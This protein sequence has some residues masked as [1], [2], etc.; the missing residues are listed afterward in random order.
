MQEV[1]HRRNPWKTVDYL[2]TFL[3]LASYNSLKAEKKG[4]AVKA[5]PALPGE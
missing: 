1:A 3:A 4:K 2:R 5:V